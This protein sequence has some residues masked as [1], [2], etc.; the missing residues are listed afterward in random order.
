MKRNQNYKQPR[1]ECDGGENFHIFL[2]IACKYRC[3]VTTR[4]GAINTD[5]RLRLLGEVQLFAVDI[6]KG[7]QNE[8]GKTV[9]LQTSLH[10]NH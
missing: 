7:G 5:T 8:L 10:W 2:E 3:T 9:A 4:L 1:V 6:K